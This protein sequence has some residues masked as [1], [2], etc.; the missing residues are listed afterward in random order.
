DLGA[1]APERRAQLDGVVR[2][3][4]AP[5]PPRPRAVRLQPPHALPARQSREPPPPRQRMARRL[6]ALVGRDAGGGGRGRP[7][8]VRPVHGARRHAPQPRRR[9]ADGDVLGRRRAGERLPPRPPR[10][11][12]PRRGGPGLHRDDVR[13]AGRPHHARLRRP[14]DRRAGGGPRP[15]RPLHPREQPG[16]GRPPARPRRPEGLGEEALGGA[17]RPHP[18]RRRQ[19]AAAGALGPPVH[20][21][22]PDAARDDARG[23][24]PRARPVRRRRPPRRRGGVRLARAPLR[25]RLPPLRLPLAAD[26][27]PHA[28]LRRPRREP[29]PLPAG[30]P[31]CPPPRLAR[32]PAR[33]RPDHGADLIDV[34]T[35]QVSKRQRPV[36]GRMW[37]T[38]FAER[39]RLETG[40]AVM[41]VGNIYEPDHVNSILAAGRADLCLLA[42]PH[43]W[44]PHWTL[45][46]AADLGYDGQWWPSQYLTGR[47]QLV[48]LVE[49]QKAG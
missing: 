13:G 15:H 16:E 47:R 6:R 34:S 40:M 44:N 19:L 21:E 43:L 49:R 28:R 10:P 3:R 9:L 45:F 39:I 8:H 11:A 36:Y 7:P 35:G 22:E 2:E 48:R 33:Q 38:P 17:R 41:A 14:L 42:R 32:G 30:G 4:R 24:G 1:Q 5:G 37:Q 20:T 29:P 46:A 23:H 25:P 31:R 27:P 18:P 26:Q 12:R